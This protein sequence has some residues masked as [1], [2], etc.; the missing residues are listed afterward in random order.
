MRRQREYREPVLRND[1][2]AIAVSKDLP[3]LHQ[4]LVR[5]IAQQDRLDRHPVQLRQRLAQ[6][7]AARI[8]IPVHQVQLVEHRRTRLRRGT[9]RVLVRA[10]FDQPVAGL[11]AH[12]DDVVARIV[13]F[14][15]ADAG[16]RARGEPCLVEGRPHSMAT[17]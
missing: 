1:D 16:C 11:R 2:F 5:A 12:R 9:I 3:D 15:R 10:Q 14:Q 6:R 13:G 7:G 8:R 17:G 4:Q